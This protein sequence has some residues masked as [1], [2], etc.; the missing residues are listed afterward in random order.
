MRQE[1]IDGSIEG[2]SE[3]VRGGKEGEWERES[4]RGIY[5][6]GEERSV[7]RREGG[8]IDRSIDVEREG[9]RGDEGGWE[10]ERRGWID[11]FG[12]IK[13]SE[14]VSRGGRGRMGRV[15]WSAHAAS[16]AGEE[17]RMGRGEINDG[18]WA[19]EERW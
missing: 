11:R 5:R 10:R 6:F 7:E 4:R 18:L 9:V 1:R 19:A 3:G 12:G 13:R 8:E 16:G 15:L 14:G 17:A 2:R